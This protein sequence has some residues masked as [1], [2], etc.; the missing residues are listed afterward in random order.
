[1]S[2][3]SRSGLSAA[4]KFPRAAALVVLIA[5][6]LFGLSA[7]ASSVS[8]VLALKDKDG[9]PL[10]TVPVKNGSVFAIRYTHSVAQTPVTDFFIIRDGSI[11]LDKTIYHDFGAG[12]PH[13]PEAGQQMTQK[14]G[15]LI[16]SGYNR[17]LPQFALR[18]GRVANHML[19]LLKNGLTDKN[20]MEIR[21]DE[22]A[23]PG[24]VIN[25]AVEAADGQTRPHMNKPD[26]H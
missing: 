19:L 7:N 11:W 17:K 6:Q 24:S 26:K 25:F 18:V 16:I 8:L 20:D 14:N 12:L 21:L 13:Q 2:L 1:M 4:R 9:V 3:V 22:L 15:E 5:L 23:P 10:L